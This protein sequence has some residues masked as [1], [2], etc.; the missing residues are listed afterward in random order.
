MKV[1]TDTG[2]WVFECHKGCLALD[3]SSWVEQGDELNLLKL[4][5]ELQELCWSVKL[6]ANLNIL[7]EIFHLNIDKGLTCSFKYFKLKEAVLLSSAPGWPR[8]ILSL[9]LRMRIWGEWW[10]GWAV[11]MAKLF[12]FC[13]PSPDWFSDADVG[14]V[15]VLCIQCTLM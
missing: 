6:K 2:I 15:C 4:E 12:N 3:M 10:A 13:P 8:F 14:S 5:P 11:E 7:K 1:G 9:G